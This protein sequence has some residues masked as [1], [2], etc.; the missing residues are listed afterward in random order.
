MLLN[1]GHLKNKYK[2]QSNGIA[3]IGAHMGQ[4]I[5]EYVK[6]FKSAEIHLFEPQK[7]IFLELKNKFNK[8]NN[9][10]FYNIAL[11][12]EVGDVILHNA[13]NE[14]Q[15]SSI[16]EPKVHLDIHPKVKFH[17]S[18]KIKISTF[19]KHDLKIVNF[20]NID[21]QGFELEVL[22]G[23]E[24]SLINN[25]D[26]IICEVNK[27]EVYKNCPL[28]SEIDTYLNR[29][30]FIRTDTHYWQDK[31]P[32]GDAFYIQKKH[33]TF[34]KLVISKVKNYFYS[35]KFLYPLL[36]KMRNFLWNLNK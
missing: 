9:I 21:T 2:M 14:G 13:N 28:I 6:Y 17:S 27:E 15:S 3:H 33:I 18:E 32:W 35:I 11:G 25:I 5:H 26:Y 29:F 22:K 1:I 36:I 31:Y 4:E 8:F 24:N 7:D 23:S 16:L 10:Y 19:D 30:G 34:Q 20:L 12:N